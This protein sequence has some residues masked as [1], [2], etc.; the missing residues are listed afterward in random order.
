[1]SDAEPT[2][3]A[4]PMLPDT[5]SARPPAL[6]AASAPPATSAPGS[7]Y[8]PARFHAKGALGEVYL[9]EDS[10]LHRAVALKRMQAHLA[11]DPGSRARFLREAE[12]T[13][14]LE[15]PGIVPVY[16]LVQGDD[17]RPCYAMR[18]IEGQSLR[19]AIEEYHRG[20][21]ATDGLALRRLLGQFVAV[22]NAVAYAHSRGILHRD[23]KPA[24]ILLGKYG[25]TLVV[26]W[27][28]A[29]PFDRDAA[30][31]ACGEETLAPTATV[32]TVE[33]TQLGQAV[34][35]PAY[36]SPEQAAGRWDVIGPAS[37]VYSLGALLYA[38]LTGRPPFPG[39]ACPLLAPVGH[40]EFVP[41]QQVQKTVPAAL[42]AI[43][44][45]ALTREPGDR[46]AGAL[47]LAADVEQWLA[48]RP[49]AVYR[50]P[51][52]QRAGRWARRHQAPVAGAAALLLTT[53]VALAVGLAVVNRE[54]R[55]THAA[56]ANLTAERQRTLAALDAE[57]RR[58]QQV[59]Q[60]LDSLSSEVI[61]DW[62][63]QQ[64]ELTGRQKEF[65]KRAMASYEEFAQ[66]TGQDQ[67]ARKDVADA[68]FRVGGIRHRL[69]EVVGAEEAYRTCQARYAELSHNFPGVPDYPHYL[70][71]THNNLGILLMD[72]G[73]PKEA[74]AEYARAIDVHR[75]LAND[76]PAVAVYRSDL[77]RHHLNQGHVLRTTGQPTEAVAAIRRGID[78]NS[79]LTH[80]F[81]DVPIYRKELA[82]DCF[83]LGL[84][85]TETGQSTAAEAEYRR[86]IDLASRLTHDFPGVPDY[87]EL[88]GESHG[89]LGLLLRDTGRRK[90][91]EEE[92]GRAIDLHSRLA[93]DY[94]SVPIYRHDLAL[95]HNNLARLLK[96]TGRLNEAETAYHRSLGLH[97]RLLHDCPA[98]TDFHH[99]FALTLT[100]L[101]QLLDGRKNYAEARRLLEEALPHHQT[102]LRADPRNPKYRARARD[103]SLVL[104]EVLA[105]LGQQAEAVAEADQPSQAGTDSATNRYDVACVLSICAPLAEKD[106]KLPES[107]RRELAHQYADR[108]VALLRQAVAK[109]WKDAA[110]MKRDPD[111]DPLRDRAD[112]R[113]LLA[114]L[115]ETN[116]A[117]K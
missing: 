104:A 21:A 12:V 107:Q 63:A 37:D 75:R 110:H 87:R 35:T 33:G 38:I 94:P 96:D 54:K 70:A 71:K 15:H 115:Q 48:D 31:R 83:S 19:E 79:R 36:M 108:A 72:T 29:K 7:R 99:S 93:G 88:L 91:A 113:Q 59:R 92:Y 95:H 89:N 64:Y 114:A 39:P 55:R 86:A 34:G 78:L 1:M 90:E 52:L 10:E 26:D 98:V 44:L 102:A 73:R 14:R 109:G 50:E 3:S 56:N 112:F 40:G 60:A 74:V 17:G 23:L 103:H 67:E 76:F 11:D 13:A 43:C 77:A 18:F 24:N 49:V 65:L 41:P 82:A 97:R 16:G 101:A 2:A 6:G 30:A 8:R 25:E 106:P 27:G 4:P 42:E 28:L 57:S 69:G 100:N 105:H 58:R 111:L 51:V 62:L 61:E 66:D 85:L 5:I 9:A 32:T 22:C 84:V 80:D 47:A 68:Y 46:Y 53:I 45:K 117:G 116:P 81:P 20:S